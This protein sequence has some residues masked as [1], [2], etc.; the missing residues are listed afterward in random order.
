MLTVLQLASSDLV[1]VCAR[2]KA[3]RRTSMSTQMRMV[4]KS[5]Y[6]KESYRGKIMIA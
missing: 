5:E 6:T 3:G 4:R 1:R 2:T